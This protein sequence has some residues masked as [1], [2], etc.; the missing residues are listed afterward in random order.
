MFFL[1]YI[2]MFFVFLIKPLYVLELSCS[3]GTREIVNGLTHP[4][5]CL[6]PLVS[7][8]SPLAFLLFILK[9]GLHKKHVTTEAS[10]DSRPLIEGWR[11]APTAERK[12]A[13]CASQSPGRS[14]STTRPGRHS[15]PA[16]AHPHA[17]RSHGSVWTY[18]LLHT[19]SLLYHCLRVISPGPAP[20]GRTHDL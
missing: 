3:S 6:S 17:P 2:F 8:P 15:M 16:P 13:W 11:A 20:K 18:Q 9:A 4:A 10:S 1:T 19:N 7:L 12:A 14:S 5:Q